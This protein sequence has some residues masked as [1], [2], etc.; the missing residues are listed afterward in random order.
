MTPR[1]PS[2]PSGGNEPAFVLPK[3]R[4]KSAAFF[5][6]VLPT[7]AILAFPS[8]ESFG[9]VATALTGLL[10]MLVLILG[11]SLIASGCLTLEAA[12]PPHRRRTAGRRGC[13]NRHI[14]P[15]PSQQAGAQQSDR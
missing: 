14:H 2:P 4:G 3:A 6:I 5:A 15:D 9:F 8:F 7:F 10:D 13:S 12:T 11:V 1:A